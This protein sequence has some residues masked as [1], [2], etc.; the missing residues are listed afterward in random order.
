M[1]SVVERYRDIQ[2]RIAAARARSACKEPV[3]LVC[4]SKRISASTIRELQDALSGDEQLF[5]GE[6][7]VQEYRE[8]RDA[9]LPHSSTMI[10]ALQRNKARDAVSLFDLIESVHSAKLALALEKEAKKQRKRVPVSLQVNISEDSLKAGFSSEEFRSVVSHW[11]DHFEWLQLC[12]VMT[13][14]AYYEEPEMARG[15]FRALTAL[16]KEVFQAFPES[17]SVQAPD[18]SMGMSS[19]FEVAIEEG[20]TSVRVGSALFGARR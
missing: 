10:G 2:R 7:Y 3:R 16:A 14:T 4:V 15:D 11:N 9:L 17:F 19:D 1:E 18:I 20:A 8:K 6:S 5:L 13:I 12:G